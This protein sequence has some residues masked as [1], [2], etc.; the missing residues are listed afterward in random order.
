MSY[1]LIIGYLLVVFGLC[2]SL[3]CTDLNPL[4]IIGPYKRLVNEMF[5]VIEPFIILMIGLLIIALGVCFVDPDELN[6]A[7]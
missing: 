6:P 7:A 5:T 2:L 4:L 3:M 1:K